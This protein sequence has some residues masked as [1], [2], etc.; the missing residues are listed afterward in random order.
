M[1]ILPE[2]L[3]EK[4][5]FVEGFVRLVPVGQ[6]ARKGSS[7]NGSIYGLLWRMGS[8]AEILILLHGIKMH[9]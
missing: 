9:S 6:N 4:I 5:R 8:T 3:K 1:L 2:S 7:I